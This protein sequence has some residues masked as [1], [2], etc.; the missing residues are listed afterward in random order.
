[1]KNEKRNELKAN[2]TK[3]MYK[4]AKSRKELRRKEKG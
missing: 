3:E 1:M 4:K 2:S